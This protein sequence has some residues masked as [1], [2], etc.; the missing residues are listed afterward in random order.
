MPEKK[1]NRILPSV[2]INVILLKN[3][4]S[5][6]DTSEVLKQLSYSSPQRY[7]AL[8][9]IRDVQFIRVSFCE[10]YD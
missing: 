5:W 9:I 7:F 8:H 4:K 1:G 3:F 6:C 10:L 2:A